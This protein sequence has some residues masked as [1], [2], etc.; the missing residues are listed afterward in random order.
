MKALLI[1]LPLLVCII[2][3][4]NIRSKQLVGAEPVDLTTEEG[5]ADISGEW[6]DNEGE[7]IG[8][9]KVT[10]AKKGEILFTP[11]K[12]KDEE[13]EEASKILIRSS[14]DY[15][16][17][18]YEPDENGER[19]WYLLGGGENELLIWT[20]NND[21][22]RKLITDGKIKGKNDPTTEK[23]A[24]GNDVQK[25]NAGAVIDDPKGEWVEKLV[26]GEFG[27][28]FD[29]KS[30]TVLRKRVAEGK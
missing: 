20:P 28:P 10:N 27:V 16:F 2:S 7:G 5:E 30:P 29:W 8:R 24:Q 14:E 1:L 18:N 22:F 13:Q 26:A 11:A 23:D 17:L 9:I 4:S 15:V 6:V 21:A 25:K 3:C 12:K 19:Q